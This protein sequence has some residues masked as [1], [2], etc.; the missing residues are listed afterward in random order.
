MGDS[1]SV[2]YEEQHGDNA[3]SDNAGRALPS[4]KDRECFEVGDRRKANGLG[5]FGQC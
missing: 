4:E 3:G 1:S 2:L 5:T